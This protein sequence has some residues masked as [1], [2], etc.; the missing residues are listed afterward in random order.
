MQDG[1][2]VHQ[3]AELST[4]RVDVVEQRPPPPQIDHLA[5]E[6]CMLGPDTVDHGGQP[7]VV[8]LARRRGELEQLIRHAAQCR[9][10]DDSWTGLASHDIAHATDGSGVADR[11][12]AE[13]H[14]DHGLGT[15]NRE[16]ME[17]LPAL[18]TT[19][20]PGRWRGRT[21]PCVGR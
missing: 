17:T 6:L 3:G 2:R 18:D 5:N 10:D 4:G 1:D 16:P 8:T 21:R 12:A 15:E 7:H 20:Q 19:A 9:D 13:L 14:D 11:R